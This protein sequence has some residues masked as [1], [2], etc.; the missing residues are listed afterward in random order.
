M[1]TNRFRGTAETSPTLSIT[2]CLLDALVV[3]W[4]TGRH[5]VLHE[6][7]GTAGVEAWA[8][9]ARFGVRGRRPGSGRAAASAG[10]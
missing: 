5:L 3:D 4:G 6:S 8:S 2:G 10:V 1:H 9:A 7:D